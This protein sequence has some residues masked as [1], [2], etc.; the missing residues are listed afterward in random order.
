M[1]ASDGGPAFPTPK[2]E[3]VFPADGPIFERPIAVPG[4]TLRDYFAAHARITWT[5]DLTEAAEV[6]YAWADALI[7]EREKPSR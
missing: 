3:M 6:A 7:A 4:M 1:S 5:R 2:G